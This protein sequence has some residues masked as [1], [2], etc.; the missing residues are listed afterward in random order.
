MDIY[1]PK[2]G[3]PVEIDYLHEVADDEDMTFSEVMRAFQVKGCPAI[4]ARCNAPSTEVDSSF[5]LRRQ[6]A[7]SALYDLLGDDIDGAAAMMEDLFG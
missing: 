6:D 5:G 7:A 3:E 2:C 1:C 4:F